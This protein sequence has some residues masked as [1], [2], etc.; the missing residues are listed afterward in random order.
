M[1]KTFNCNTE[2]SQKVHSFGQLGTCNFMTQLI[3]LHGWTSS[4]YKYFIQ[5]MLI[6]PQMNKILFSFKIFYN[7]TCVKGAGGG[8]HLGIFKIEFSVVHDRGEPQLPNT[9][10]RIKKYLSQP[11]LS[12]L[13]ILNLLVITLR[14]Q[15]LIAICRK[16]KIWPQKSK[17]IF[18]FLR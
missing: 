6:V 1:Q 15:T 5:Y 2:K 12:Q 8:P 17:L 11:K 10:Y 3:K 4:S 13:Q 16:R 18:H 9:F 7:R 14:A